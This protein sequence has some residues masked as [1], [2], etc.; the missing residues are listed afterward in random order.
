MKLGNFNLFDSMNAAIYDPTTNVKSSHHHHHHHSMINGN[1]HAQTIYSN[2]SDYNPSNGYWPY[3]NQTFLTGSSTRQYIVPTTSSDTSSTN[4]TDL[5]YS[6]HSHTSYATMPKM[7]T[8][9]SSPYELYP[10]SKYC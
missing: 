4:R 8:N 6:T 10:N 5:N 7:S 1:Q 2:N 3:P 9:Y